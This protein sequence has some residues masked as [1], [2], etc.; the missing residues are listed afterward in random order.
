LTLDEV[1]GE[2]EPIFAQAP[3]LDEAHIESISDHPRP[4][5]GRLSGLL[6]AVLGEEDADEPGEASSSN[7]AWS[8]GSVAEVP[9]DSEQ[10][11]VMR[12]DELTRPQSVPGSV[13][14][15]EISAVD[16]EDLEV[17][18]GSSVSLSDLG[19]STEALRTTGQ[20]IEYDDQQVRLVWGAT[21][22]EA[23]WFQKAHLEVRFQQLVAPQGRAWVLGLFE[24]FE[25]GKLRDVVSWQL[26]PG[27]TIHDMVIGALAERFDV[28]I[29]CLGANGDFSQRRHLK[30]PLEENV[31]RALD[32]VAERGDASA[33]EHVMAKDFDRCGK[34]QHNFKKDSFDALKNASEV[35]L[36]LGIVGYWSLENLTDHLLDVLSFPA[37]WFDAIVKRVLKNAIDMGLAFEPHLRSLAVAEGLVEDEAVLLSRLVENFGESMLL[38]DN[39]G[40]DLLEQ[41]ENWE[42]LLTWADVMGVEI[43]TDRQSQALA[44]LEA[45][46]AAEAGPMG[47][48]PGT[49]GSIELSIRDALV[50][51]SMNSVVGLA[52]EQGQTAWD[53][54]TDA[55][56]V[57]LL[58][59]DGLSPQPVYE[60]LRRSDQMYAPAVFEAVWRLPAKALE[61][62][63]P[64][65]A[66][67][68]EAYADMLVAEL[69]AP[70]PNNA[71]AGVVLAELGDARAA[72]PLLNMMK[73]RDGAAAEVLA[74]GVARLGATV[75]E[76]VFAAEVV[77]AVPNERLARIVMMVGTDAIKGLNTDGMGAA[78]N[79]I[80][81]QAK[82]M[83]DTDGS[84]R[85]ASFARWLPTV[86]VAVN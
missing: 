4:S 30:P 67:R 33:L 71:L 85:M 83:L 72:A 46:H 43:P 77:E 7:E 35:R 25:D 52:S 86:V 17:I 66:E 22:S 59:G 47:E 61:V 79:D 24:R 12:R 53:E 82:K 78:A 55:S 11:N 60:L 65:L 16:S 49:G 81:A 68:G 70:W 3:K 57:E 9:S 74:E 54:L 15:S 8:L 48:F 6:A 14:Q 76:S 56:L 2:S 13:D 50:V 1:P 27:N 84:H 28:E 41:W 20:W 31:A 10:T 23:E 29:A 73:D 42:R 62:A 51:E 26:E 39:S 21:S 36:S 37:V 5:T 32:H 40:L 69:A 63:L 64:M 38:P 45:A 34:P 19:D 58:H 80:I 44:A 75:L 18:D